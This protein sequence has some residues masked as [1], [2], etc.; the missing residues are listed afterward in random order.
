MGGLHQSLITHA[1]LKSSDTDL[2]SVVI[3]FFILGSEGGS[4]IGIGI[5]SVIADCLCKRA[6]ACKQT[7]LSLTRHDVC[8]MNAMHATDRFMPVLVTSRYI[9]FDLVVLHFLASHQIETL[10]MGATTVLLS[11]LAPQDRQ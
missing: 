2:E 6:I 10:G 4:K 8:A 9:P 3:L 7:C 5:H 11:C 1:L